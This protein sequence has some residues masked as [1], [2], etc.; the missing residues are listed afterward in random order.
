LGAQAWNTVW[1]KVGI[2]ARAAA[3][4]AALTIFLVMVI[5]FSPGA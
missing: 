4:A 5:S 1:A 3:K 2:V